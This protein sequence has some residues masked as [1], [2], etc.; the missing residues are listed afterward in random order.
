MIELMQS[1]NWA[2]RP[3]ESVLEYDKR[4]TDQRREYWAVRHS[5][6]RPILKAV[7]GGTVSIEY[8]KQIDMESVKQDQIDGGKTNNRGR[9]ICPYCSRTPEVF[10]G[11]Y[12]FIRS[13]GW[14]KILDPDYPEGFI[15]KGGV[16]ATCL[17][18]KQRQIDRMKKEHPVI[19]RRA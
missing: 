19:K 5:Y 15:D 9:W 13:T 2:Q 18:V 12:I 14:M 7:P 11:K 3:D 17:C 10:Y 4:I 16:F 1:K 6:G 8:S